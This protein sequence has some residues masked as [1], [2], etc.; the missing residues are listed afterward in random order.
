[1]K[2]IVVSEIVAS[3]PLERPPP[4]AAEFPLILLELMVALPPNGLAMPPP[5]PVPLATLATT[6][7]L[8]KVSLT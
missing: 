6:D 1:M 5:S 3:P 2:A 7:V 4:R 8:F